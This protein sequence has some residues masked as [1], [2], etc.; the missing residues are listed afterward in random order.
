MEATFCSIVSHSVYLINRV[1]SWAE[2]CRND[3]YSS[4]FVPYPRNNYNFHSYPF[5][6]VIPILIFSITAISSSPYP[7]TT[8]QKCVCRHALEHI[9]PYRIKPLSSFFL[10]YSFIDRQLSVLNTLTGQ[11]QPSIS[12]LTTAALTD[13][14]AWV[15]IYHPT[16]HRIQCDWDSFTRMKYIIPI[17]PTGS[18][19]SLHMGFPHA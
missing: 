19:L 17:I 8:S 12:S 14:V 4:K 3:F 2:V 18:S 11:Y 15:T 7:I 13:D 1:G 10:V 16:S 5:L 6:Y 9:L